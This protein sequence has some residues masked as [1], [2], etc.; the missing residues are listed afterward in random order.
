MQ[1]TQI[2][3]IFNSLWTETSS[4]FMLYIPHLETVVIPAAAFV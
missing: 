1:Y 3:W 2:R 4:Y